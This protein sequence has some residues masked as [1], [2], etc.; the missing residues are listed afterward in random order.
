MIRRIVCMTFRTDAI[1]DFLDLFEKRKDQIRYFPGC[2]HLELWQD[3]QNPQ[4]FFTYSWWE[5]E[6]N[7]EA[8]RHSD[9][10]KETWSST[11]A[12]FADR[13]RAW[14]LDQLHYL[15]GEKNAL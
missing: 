12:L 4:V 7:L 3:R 2:R 11:K 6:D 13:P 5:A 15:P 8:Y 14:S 10:F 1:D 9:L